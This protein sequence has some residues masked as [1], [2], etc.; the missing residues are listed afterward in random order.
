[1]F[2]LGKE[3]DRDNNL[4]NL[5][6]S[7]VLSQWSGWRSSAWWIGS[8]RRSPTC[9]RSASCCGR[10][11][12]WPRLLTPTWARRA[13]CSGFLTGKCLSEV[14]G[15]RV[16]DGPDLLDAVRRVV[17]RHR[18]MGDVLLCQDALPQHEPSERGFLT[19]STRDINPLIHKNASSFLNLGIP[20]C[21]KTSL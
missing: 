19:N 3:Q 10:C 15:D 7:R 16:H 18:A 9:G 20:P 12:P 6:H 14:T 11:S 4:L 5:M 8:S 2:Y 13:C 21:P 1:M 17:V